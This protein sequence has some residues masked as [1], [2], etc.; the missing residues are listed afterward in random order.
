MFVLALCGLL[1]DWCVPVLDL[2]LH[3]I[4]CM[5]GHSI[6]KN[7]VS[8]KLF[9]H[10]KK[11]FCTCTSN[12]CDTECHYY[13]LRNSW[14]ILQ[15]DDLTWSTDL[16]LKWLRWNWLLRDVNNLLDMIQRFPFIQFGAFCNNGAN[17]VHWLPNLGYVLHMNTWDMHKSFS[18]TGKN[19]KMLN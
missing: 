18:K 19:Y 5:I 17:D 13:A 16:L 8:F 14:I 11:C 10:Q 1:F 9:H 3:L 6:T 7:G 4:S 15:L 2:I 12:G